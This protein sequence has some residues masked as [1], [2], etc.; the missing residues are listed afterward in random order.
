MLTY[1]MEDTGDRC[2]RI[3]FRSAGPLLLHGIVDE[4][5]QKVIVSMVTF[6]FDQ[7]QLCRAVSSHRRKQQV[8]DSSNAWY[9]LAISAV[10]KSGT[11]NIASYT[12]QE[13]R[14]AGQ[15]EDGTSSRSVFSGFIDEATFIQLP[16]SLL[17]AAQGKPMVRYN[18]NYVV[19]TTKWSILLSW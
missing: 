3:A 4:D 8:S 9:T 1:A 14:R 17:N 15:N 18:S 7:F 6:C 13:G 10:S 16:L 5:G 12:Q 2:A 11:R 19:S